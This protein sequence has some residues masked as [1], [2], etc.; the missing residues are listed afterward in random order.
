MVIYGNDNKETYNIPTN[1]K[2]TVI[3]ILL[4]EVFTF[5]NT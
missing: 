5:K 3:I 4:F 2:A 1:Q